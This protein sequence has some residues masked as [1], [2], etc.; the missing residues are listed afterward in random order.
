[1]GHNI[2]GLNSD[3][4]KLNLLIKYCTNKG[5]DIVGICETNRDRKYGEYWN[6]QNLEYISF[7]TNKDNKVKGSRVCII[8]NKKWEK[9]VGKVSKIDAYYIKAWLLFK[10]CM[11]IVGVIYISSDIK[12]QNKLT[13][14]IKKEFVNHSKKNKYYILIS[15]LNSYI[16][17]QNIT[18][19]Q[20]I[21]T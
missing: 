17:R 6:K 10:N 5:T 18:L 15:D 13:G 8:I 9:Y 19:Q 2:N 3:H 16:Y 1:M 20:S 12:K 14:Y 21:Q 7:W 4:S 11:L